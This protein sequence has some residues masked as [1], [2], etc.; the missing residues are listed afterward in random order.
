MTDALLERIASALERLA[1]ADPPPIDR[2]A[3]AFRWEGGR[4]RPV[5]EFAPLPLTLLTG[6][7]TQRDALFEN[8]QRLANGLAAHDALL[9]GV[10]GS[11]KSALVSAVVG[12]L[13]AGGSQIALVEIATDSLDSVASLMAEVSGWDRPI[14]LF[15][16]DLAFDQMGSALRSLRSLLAGGVV[17]RPAHVR[18]YVTSN[19][20][21]IVARDMA[22]EESA[23]NAH[24][25]SEDQLAL[26]DRFGLSLG[27]H[28]CDQDRY[29]A[30]VAGYAA[31]IGVVFDPADAIQWATQRGARSGRVAWHYAVELA[32]RAGKLL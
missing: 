24:D 29:I 27:F 6:I 9:W 25:V 5:P 16:D 18:L 26:A 10:R 20:R 21:T 17:S 12:A 14:L 8:S 22:A 7:D 15:I 4:L 31:H 11:G 32:G 28:A 19:R 1:P 13:Q 2:A 3:P 30:M 23:I